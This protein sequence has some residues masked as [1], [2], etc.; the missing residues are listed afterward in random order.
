MVRGKRASCKSQPAM[1]P[2][3]SF[4]EPS[5]AACTTCSHARWSLSGHD[6]C[7]HSFR[8]SPGATLCA[9]SAASTRNVPDPHMQ[10]TKE[11]PAESKSWLQEVHAA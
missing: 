7:P 6:K 3:Q 1:M 4:R 9:M 5:I 11:P 8:N 10:S 2:F